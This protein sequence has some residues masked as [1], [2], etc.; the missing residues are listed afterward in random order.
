M[1]KYL[2]KR[3]HNSMQKIAGIFF[4]ILLVSGVMFTD[5][6]IKAESNA[7]AGEISTAA[8]AEVTNTASFSTDVIYQ[9]V[10]DRFFDG[11][12]GNDYAGEIFNKSDA[13]K[14]HGG[15]WAG[16]TEKLNDG[17]LTGLGVSA[18][19]ISSPV[20]NISTIDP[21]NGC[22]SYH[23]YWAKDYFKTNE[24]FGSM[25]DFTN[26]VQTAHEKGI[27]IVIDFALNHTSTAEYGTT[28]FPEDGSLYKD[29]AL[30]GGFTND[31]QGIFNHESWTN[32][33]TYENGIFH[34]LYG[35]ADLNQQNS[36]VDS[37]L[38]EATQK[39]LA[40]GVDGI[41]VDAAKHMT[42][43]W[44]K[45]WLSSIYSDKPVFTFGEWYNGG[46]T[47]ESDMTN[48]ANE[49]GMNL[50]D[51]RFANA[52]RN[53]L[54]TGSSTMKD[55]YDVVV[56]TASDYEEV[57]DQVTFIDNHDMS[58]FTT[59]AGNNQHSVDNAYVILL[60]SRGVPT[61]YY[62][63]EQYLTGT[64]DH[65]NRKDMPSFDMGSSA[66]KVISYLAPLRKRNP[67]L[68]YGT[69]KERWMNDDVIVYE[70]QFGENVVVT[71][72][73][74][75]QSNSYSISGLNAN[76]PAGRYSDVMN[77]ILGGG[78]INVS[79][80]G[81]VNT[82][83]LGAGQSA[84]WQ[85]TADS[86]DTPIIGDVD[87]LM[88]IAGNTVTITGRGFGS[89]AGMVSF[90]DSSAEVKSW[91]DSEIQVVVPEVAAGKYD[92]KV[93]TSA[94]IT[95]SAYSGF[96]VLTGEQTSVRFKVNNATTD[97]GT[98]IYLVGN[99][100]EL[101][102]W[103][104]TKAI[105]PLFNSTSTIGMYPTWFCDVNVPAGKTIEYKFIKKDASG[106]VIWESGSNHRM[107]TPRSGVDTV[108]TDWQN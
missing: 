33:S 88:G 87:P 10:T 5:V 53:T 89:T 92:I 25:N 60:T 41:R 106:K 49:S 26:M 45:N 107:T 102:N 28:Y 24:Y 61:I 18:L 90:D 44:Q 93:T 51:F 46:V 86:N 78:S 99:V 1:N 43:G 3:Y 65:D 95:S 104:A 55:L 84:V 81:A 105:G 101:G 15:D 68:A 67:A 58:R 16:I 19:W 36:T 12:T 13:K 31:T 79:Q 70:R 48:F 98:N 91:S 34:S 73:N 42:L 39:W 37:Y 14:Y 64:T 100:Y 77:G 7:V 75:N 20:E 94:E 69:T 50:L 96:E 72:V 83:T 71:A 23:G 47:A 32:F 11:D 4:V 108:T 38:K 74:R 82:F 52:V 29:G 59:L 66:Y 2:K 80:K 57:N 27:K 97:Y 54:G 21:S 9:I 6:P 76:L 22:A 56:D 30:V 8:D 35:L 62:G 103:D 63:S 40:L 17:Y 85:Y